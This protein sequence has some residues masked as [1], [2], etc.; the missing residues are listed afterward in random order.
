MRTHVFAARTLERPASQTQ[1]VYELE[2][3]AAVTSVS[4][5]SVGTHD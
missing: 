5:N 3:H 4:W 1:S 2:M